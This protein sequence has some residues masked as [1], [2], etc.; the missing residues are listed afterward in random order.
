MAS[1]LH[2]T[3]RL[4]LAS[5][6][7]SELSGL[8]RRLPQR[9]QQ[10]QKKR[11]WRRPQPRQHLEEEAEGE[12]GS[13]LASGKRG[14]KMCSQLL[15]SH[16]RVAQISSGPS[17]GKDEEAPFPCSMS[18]ELGWSKLISRVGHDFASPEAIRRLMRTNC[19]RSVAPAAQ[20]HS[21]SLS[22]FY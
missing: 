15:G 2:I 6:Q 14:V 12:G 21:L 22:L 20:F 19:C 9:Q 1:G 4:A 3:S 8:P 11:Q 5:W 7:A 18:A 16:A 13:W 10:Q 17:N